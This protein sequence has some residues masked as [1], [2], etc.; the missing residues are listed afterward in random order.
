MPRIIQVLNRFVIGGPSVIITSLTKYLAP[1]FESLLIVGAKEPHE[2]EISHLMAGLDIEMV[3]IKDM[4][5]AINPFL[6]FKSYQAVKKVI[7]DFKP[8]I[9]HTHSAKPGIIGRMAAHHCNVKTIVHTFHGHA[10]HSYFG[11]TTTKA[12]IQTER[13]LAGI[14]DGIIAISKQQVHE[15]AHV[16][17]ICPE[18]KLKLIPIGLE[19]ERFYTNKNE[20]RKKFREKFLIADD[21]I[22]FA[23]IGRIVAIKNH[24]R[25][26]EIADGVLKKTN[27]KIRFVIIGDGDAREQM[28]A[29]IAAKKLD[30]CYYPQDNRAATLICTSWIEEIDEALAGVDIV[31]LTSD[32]EGT[33]VSLIEAQAAGIPVVSTNI[34]GVAD[35]VADGTSGFLV[36]PENTGSFINQAIKLIDDPALRLQMGEAGRLF[37]IDNFSRNVMVRDTAAYYHSLIERQTQV[38]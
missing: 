9:V 15:L 34:G 37:V 28:E 12:I 7:R 38:F 11:K 5:R 14:S 21:E 22:V 29:D 3:E 4:K 2:K 19:L 35:A 16:Y 18:S 20:K 36:S 26:V 30:Y 31:A 33:P 1:E 8:D 10:F 17:K 24:R 32:N 25:F 23:I 13:Y 6:D 27:K